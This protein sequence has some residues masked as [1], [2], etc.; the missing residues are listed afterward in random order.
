MNE[1]TNTSM[2]MI[3]GNLVDVFEFKSSDVLAWDIAWSL[4]LQNRYLGH[5]PM[6]WDVLSHTALCYSIAMVEHHRDGKTMNPYDQ[7]GILLHDAAEAY[8]GDMIR[9]LK[10]YF[11]EFTTIEDKVLKVILHRFGVDTAAVNWTLVKEYD[12]KALWTEQAKFN[13]FNDKV[14]GNS[15][16]DASTTKNMMA[17]A[18][19][20]QYL[21]VLRNLCVQ[22]NTRSINELFL[23]PETLR[24]YT[25]APG[26]TPKPQRTMT[27]PDYPVQAARQLDGDGLPQIE[28]SALDV[29]ESTRDIDNL[30]A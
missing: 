24:G 27:R 26:E 25:R 14:Y 6:A 13:R 4:S 2:G 8:M 16:Y 12:Q 11:V 7:L 18:T 3:S 20:L 15:N 9:P 17:K 21:E 19:P 10:S 28:D 29:R 30:R 22:I 23:F 1:Q 5:T